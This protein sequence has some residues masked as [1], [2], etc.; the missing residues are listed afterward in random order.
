MHA[1]AFWPGLSSGEQPC[2]VAHT[3]ARF[4]TG[5]LK[6]KPRLASWPQALQRQG[7]VNTVQTHK[8]DPPAAIW[9]KQGAPSLGSL[10]PS[11]NALRRCV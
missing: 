10:H 1:G 2:D 4:E 6:T 3:T 5:G 8:V 9:L 7:E 11:W